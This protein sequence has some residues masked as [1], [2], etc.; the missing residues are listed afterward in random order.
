MTTLPGNVETQM[1]NSLLISVEKLLY[2]TVIRPVIVLV[3]IKFLEI[4]LMKQ[5]M[6]L[7]K[8]KFHLQKDLHRYNFIDPSF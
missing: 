1:T 5:Q 4:R 2:Y 3:C 7:E 8:W 6:L